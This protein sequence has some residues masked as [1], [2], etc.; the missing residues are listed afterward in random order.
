VKLK[1][2]IVDLELS[3]K[4]KKRLAF[5]VPLALVL[6]SGA[7]AFA[8][9]DWAL[10]HEWSNSAGPT[11]AG[12]NLKASDLDD[13]FN[14][15]SDAGAALE[16]RVSNLE[17]AGGPAGPSVYVNPMTGKQYSLNAGYCGSTA[18][19][20]DGNLLTEEPSADT[21]YAAAKILC[22]NV[23]G[24]A[25]AA[26]TAHMCTADEII[27][28]VATGGVMPS[29]QGWFATGVFYSYYTPTAYVD[30]NDCSAYTSAAVSGPGSGPWGSV[31]NGGGSSPGPD[32]G[33]CGAMHAVLCCN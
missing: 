1:I 16:A 28:Y 9:M 8:G 22:E 6:A 33:D 17:D 25:S 2:V 26:Q 30:G 32:D 7:V 10:P 18:M 11:Y 20:Y 5:G 15:L 4:A 19:A 21:G 29:A 27:R 24:C 14:A 12:P 23:P 3:T 13:N 31:W